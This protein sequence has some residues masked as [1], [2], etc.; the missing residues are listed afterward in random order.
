MTFLTLILA[1]VLLYVRG[2]G[3]PVQRDQLFYRWQSRVAAWNLGQ[4]VG[5][6]LVVLLPALLAAWLLDAIDRVLFGLV[7]IAVATVLLLYS[8]GRGDF[9]ELIARYRYFLAAADYQGA[10]IALSRALGCGFEAAPES[11]ADRHQRLLRAIVYEA[12]QRWFAVLLYFL[13]FGPAGA[14]AYRLLQLCRYQFAAPLVER[15][16]FFADWLPSRLLAATFM[17][18]GNFVLSRN[19]LRDALRDT[20][21]SADVVLAQVACAAVT[22]DAPSAD[23][24]DFGRTASEHIAG[25]RSLLSR[26]AA[27]WVAVIAL[28]VLID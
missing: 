4:A 13:L 23:D 14:L 2:S 7:W 8:F 18:A 12:C 15:C 6:G 27:C 10:W 20:G 3:G 9:D 25:V 11:T 24:A 5:L 21:L 28:W 26:S 16:L 17:L 1:L 22:E 19:V